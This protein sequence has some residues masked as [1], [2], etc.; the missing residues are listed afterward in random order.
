M[1]KK[2]YSLFLVF[3]WISLTQTIFAQC[4]TDPAK[5][6]QVF[7]EKSASLTSL[8]SEG[9]IAIGEDLN[10]NGNYQVA[11]KTAGTFYVNN[12]LI[13]LLV[14]GKV[15][16]RS[17]N[18]FQINNGYV[19][20]GNLENS[21]VWF[22]DE[23]G[24][25]N[26]MQICNGSY[27]SSPRIQLLNKAKSLNVSDSK[28]EVEDKD[29]IDFGKAMETMRASSK[30]LGAKSNNVLLTDQNDLPVVVNK[31]PSLVKCSLNRGIN[32]LC[33]SGNDLNS[34]SEITCKNKP[35]ANHVL[36]INVDAKDGFNWQVWKHNGVGIGECPYILFNFYNTTD[37]NIEGS[38][39]IEGTVFAP[40]ADIHKKKNNSNVEGQIIGVSYEQ[41][42]G[43]N[44][45]ANFDA[46]AEEKGCKKPTVAAITGN[47][48]VCLGL[49]TTLNSATPG[50]LWSTSANNVGAINN[51][52]VV[53][54][55]AK[56]N[57][58]ISYSVNNSCGTTTVTTAIT[59]N[60]C[61]TVNSGN[62]GGLESKSLGDAVAKRVFAAAINGELVMKP[63]TQL[64][65]LKQV[66]IS[67]QVTGIGSQINLID[68]FPKQ[69]SNAA[70][71]PYITTPADI[72]SF[73][74]AK[75]V[76][77]SDYTLNGTCKAVVFATR[78]QSAI[79]DHT[80]AVCDRLK[81]ATIQNL[82]K[83]NLL[84]F[85]ILRYN[86][87]YEDGHQENIISFSAGTKAGRNS[88][89][90]Q[91]NWLKNDYV[92]EDDMYNFQVWGVSNDIL[93]EIAQRL[94]EQLS[95]MAPLEQPYLVKPLPKTYIMSAS[96]DLGAIEMNLHNTDQNVNGYFDIFENANEKSVLVNKKN[97]P[98]AISTNNNS[99]IKLPASDVYESTIKMY[100]NDTLA[101]EIFVSDGAWNIDYVAANTVVN[102][103]EIMNDA[104]RTVVSDEYP[105]Y[106]NIHLEAATNTYVSAY[107]LLRGGGISKDL[108]G[109]KT[110]KFTASGNAVLN[111]TLVKSSVKNWDDQY[112][113]HIPISTDAKEYGIDLNDFISKASTD[114]INPNDINSI[115]FTMGSMNG[116]MTNINA[117][118]SNLAFSK[119]SLSYLDALK[120]KAISVYPNPTSG[121]F[122]CVF[123]SDKSMD[124]NLMVTDAYSGIKLLTKTIAIEKGENKIPVDIS[125]SYQTTAGGACV[126]SVNNSETNY[127]SKKL[128]IKPN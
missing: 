119:E 53:T 69:L 88:F 76:A 14:N 2:I 75:A 23:K 44:H 37:L 13:A 123:N 40:G 125:A 110:L 91:S 128:I 50:G 68:L 114:K 70:I 15:N 109:Y 78:T 112:A 63:Y 122:Y 49:T 107:K 26:D 60:D 113:L 71:T 90:I 83:I 111:I 43:E 86:M 115:V 74:N 8:A 42:E 87:K 58:I 77:S 32:Y 30:A 121:R 79:Y 62:T 9:P 103:F 47:N 55:V 105:V 97:I 35:D 1:F 41:E 64:P 80:K 57:F 20:I 95:V 4:P 102:K 3:I 5:G 99:I 22:T 19:K 33:I 11:V 52:G 39:A 84:G 10:I 67:R 96:N 85:D 29:L 117:S 118:L 93:G 51:T 54:G 124:A 61:G 127:S 27:N 24:T 59:T 6:F 108:T 21:K 45:N 31:Y 46:D 82:E 72:I 17:G 48:T 94:L 56:G 100:L 104:K 16:Y 120:S 38:N 81:G 18:S 98:F 7:V 25:Y 106:R 89:T 28:K 92:L 36:V 101:D 12:S 34:I 126:I 65:I 116:A 73:T 66:L